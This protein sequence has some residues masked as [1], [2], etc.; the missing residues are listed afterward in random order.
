[1]W[2]K[3]AGK[4]KMSLMRCKSSRSMAFDR[5]QRRVVQF[6]TTNDPP[7]RGGTKKGGGGKKG[8][9]VKWEIAMEKSKILGGTGKNCGENRRGEQYGG[10]PKVGGWGVR[11]IRTMC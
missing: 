4:N 11:R 6:A 9:S 7:D 1:M 2:G 8:Q 10:N 5:T 3:S